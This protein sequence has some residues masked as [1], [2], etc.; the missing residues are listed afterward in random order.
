MKTDENRTKTKKKGLLRLKG[1]LCAAFAAAIVCSGYS[2]PN[3]FAHL[4][5]HD[6]EVP[7]AT[8]SAPQGLAWNQ[9]ALTLIKSRE[10]SY[11]W[12][13]IHAFGAVAN[14]YYQDYTNWDDMIDHQKAE[15]RDPAKV[16]A[17]RTFLDAFNVY[18]HEPLPQMA[19]DVNGA[20]RKNISYYLGFKS[21]KFPDPAYYWAP[22]IQTVLAGKGDCKAY[23][24]LQYAV[25]RHLGVP[26]DRLAIAFV[27]SSGMHDN[28]DHAVL[29]VNVAPAGKA[30]DFLVMNDSGPVLDASLYTRPGGANDTW[31]RPYVFFDAMNR[32]NVWTTPLENKILSHP[33]PAKKTLPKVV[34]DPLSV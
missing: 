24:I 22:P 19:K 27:N 9:D 15:M 29:I 3:A 20:V 25:M 16:Q 8:Q 13:S 7:V 31:S 33:K 12:Y 2:T 17:Y 21:K 32:D 4:T 26:E 6:M 5:P 18:A 30:Q 28:T 34:N 14:P 23:V 1:T 11:A 10:K